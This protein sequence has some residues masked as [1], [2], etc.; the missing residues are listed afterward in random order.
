MLRFRRKEIVTNQQI[1]KVIVNK[2]KDSL[3]Q[4][5]RSYRDRLAEGH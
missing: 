3:T 5:C 2:L 4:A 1:I